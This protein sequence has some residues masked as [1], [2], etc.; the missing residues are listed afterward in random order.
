[1][2]LLAIDSKGTLFILVNTDLPVLSI[3]EEHL[4]I[5]IL[6]DLSRVLIL[7][8]LDVLQGLNSIILR[9]SALVADTLGVAEERWSNWLNRALGALCKLANNLDVV[10]SSPVRWKDWK[11]EGGNLGLH[12]VSCTVLSW[13]ARGVVL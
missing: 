7:N 4:W 8:L 11:W 5:L 3:A 12:V 13:F 6:G 9:E 1:M 10:L 2:R